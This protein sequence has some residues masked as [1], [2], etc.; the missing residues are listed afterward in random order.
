M[1]LIGSVIPININ[2]VHLW[3]IIYS[4]RYDNPSLRSGIMKMDH[5]QKHTN[6]SEFKII[7]TLL[8]GYIK[9]APGNATEQSNLMTYLEK[10]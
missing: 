6:I 8:L 9:S 10:Q 4:L 7:S 2:L 1:V 5:N 3:L